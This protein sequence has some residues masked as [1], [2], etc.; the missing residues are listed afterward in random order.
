[1]AAGPLLVHTFVSWINRTVLKRRV[2]AFTAALAVAMQ[3]L[4]VLV[5]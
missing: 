2:F 5:I 3:T 1:M 4:A